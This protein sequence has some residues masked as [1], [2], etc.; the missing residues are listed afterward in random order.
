M[1]VTTLTCRGEDE[2]GCPVDGRAFHNAVIVRKAISLMDG[3]NCLGGDPYGAR[4]RVGA[5]GSS[6]RR[7]VAHMID[8]PLCSFQSAGPPSRKTAAS[9]EVVQR[10]SSPAVQPHDLLSRSAADSLCT[11]TKTLSFMNNQ[12][13]LRTTPPPGR[14]WIWIYFKRA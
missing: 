3:P 7:L 4:A 10:R 1:S 9:D 13:S 14:P 5:G 11:A 12:G 2:C 6:V 8:R